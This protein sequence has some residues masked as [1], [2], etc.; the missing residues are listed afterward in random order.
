LS[1]NVSEFKWNQR[2]EAKQQEIHSLIKK[3]EIDISAKVF[4]RI[5]R[6]KE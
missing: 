3:R 2:K 6:E 1:K 4:L 5:Y